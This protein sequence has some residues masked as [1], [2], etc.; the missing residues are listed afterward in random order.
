[1]MTVGS[2]ARYMDDLA[3]QVNKSAVNYCD[4]QQLDS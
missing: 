4:Q 2:N 3:Q 1:M